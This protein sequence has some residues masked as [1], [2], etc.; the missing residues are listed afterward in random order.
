[1]KIKSLI[2]ALCIS[3]LVIGA[4][5]A[6]ND[7]VHAEEKDIQWRAYDEGIDLAGRQG[8]KVFLHFYT[9]WCHFC[10]VMVEK[11]FAEQDVISLLNEK[12]VAI[13]VNSEEK[14]ALAEKYS[15]RGVPVNWFLEENGEKIGSRPGYLPP[16]DFMTL[17]KFVVQEKYKQ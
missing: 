11:T 17:L 5:S 7:D 9:D 12:F 6:G 3:V 8:K 10:K 14:Q 4:C 2:A 13:R 15:V 16:E 1:M